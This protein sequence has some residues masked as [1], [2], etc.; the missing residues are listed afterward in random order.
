MILITNCYLDLLAKYY[1][2]VVIK[3]VPCGQPGISNPPNRK[4]VNY[5]ISCFVT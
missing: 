4:F 1:T 5:E 3:S 2:A